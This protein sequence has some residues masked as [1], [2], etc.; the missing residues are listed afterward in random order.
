MSNWSSIQFE[1]LM[2]LCLSPAENPASQHVLS[3]TQRAAAKAV[4]DS[5]ASGDLVA[6]EGEA[7]VGKSTIL[8]HVQELKGGVYLGMREFM[9]ARANRQPLAIDEA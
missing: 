7:G 9:A 8:R 4:L 3:P 2:Q 5:I 6:L 1:G